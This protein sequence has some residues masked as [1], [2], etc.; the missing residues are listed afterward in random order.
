MIFHTKS[1]EGMGFAPGKSSSSKAGT[2]EY[3]ASWARVLLGFVLILVIL[4]GALLA[5]RW[6]WPEGSQSLL[7]MGEV[8][9]GGMVGL[10]FGERTGMTAQK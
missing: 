7:H 3:H 5:H 8:A 2:E 6:D 10:F 9:F 4:G 1:S